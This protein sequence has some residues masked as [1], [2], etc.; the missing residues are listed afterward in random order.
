LKNNEPGREALAHKCYNNRMT[1]HNYYKGY[2]TPRQLKLPLDLERIIDISDP[3]YSFSE[4][5]DCIDFAKYFAVKERRTGRP[6]YNP[7]T[8][9]KIVLFS[10]MEN[11]YLSLRNIEKSC[12]TD[13]R[14]MWLLD[15]M[16][17]PTFATFGNFIRDELTSSIEDIFLAINTVIFERDSV[18]LTHTYIDG[19]KIE[20]NAN[21]YTWVWKKSCIKNRDK[22][23]LKISELIKEINSDDLSFLGIRFEPREEYAVEYLE[24]LIDKYKDIYSLTPDSFAS[25]RGHRKTPQQRR[26][27]KLVELKDRLIRYSESIDI[28]GEYRNSYSKTDHS[29]S[30]MRVKTDYMG[31]D[32]LLPAYNMQMAICDEYIAAVDVKQYA[33]DMECFMPLMEKFNEFYGHYPKYPVADAGY[34][35]FNNYIYCQEHGMEK[36]M[37]FPMFE[38]ETR[39]SKYRNNPYRAVNFAIDK[40]GDL[41]CPGGRKFALKR[42]Q[43]I[44]GNKYGRTEEIYECENC[45]G[46]EH[47]EKCCPRVKGNRTVQIN[48]ELTS[49]HE[50]VV[51]NL[52]SIHG[53][54][55][56]MNRSIQAEGTYGAIKWDRSYK[57]AYRRG[58]E[59]IN[60]EFY[61][62]SCGY[63]LYKYHNKAKRN[64]LSA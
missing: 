29:A 54:L 13:I 53:A 64:V 19:T 23:F 2:S 21:K 43:A 32:Q 18:D 35:S 57:R 44:R 25:G 4:I 1:K 41:R 58:L 39:D 50:E 34:G 3:V 24:L 26:Y 27:Q 31:N 14:Y 59:S 37:K 40:K 30:F 47:K 56:C 46:C 48:R 8:M 28:C 45:E 42:N 17:A 63:N 7:T 55:L 52:G 61:L 6:R 16:E 38:K 60:L 9:L 51:K 10:F 49:V 22:M 12:K 62:I 15:G 36:Y 20:A 5:V 33:S 11:G